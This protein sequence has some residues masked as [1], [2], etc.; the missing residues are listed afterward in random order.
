MAN[1]LPI[2]HLHHGWGSGLVSKDS[3]L[4]PK[5]SHGSSTHVAA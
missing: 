1:L 3:A 4:H 5:I 2:V